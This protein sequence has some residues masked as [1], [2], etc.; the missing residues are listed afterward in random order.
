MAFELQKKEQVCRLGSVAGPK[1]AQ[2]INFS[3]AAHASRWI[4]HH[5]EI[6]PLKGITLP[7]QSPPLTIDGPK[8]RIIPGDW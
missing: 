1:L 4:F 3:V 6:A 8:G 7:P 5:P 2:G